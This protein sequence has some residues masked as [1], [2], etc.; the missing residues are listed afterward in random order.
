MHTT[1]VLC[2]DCAAPEG[3]LH[4]FFPYCDQEICPLCLEQLC[5]CP[6]VEALE[7]VEKA[8]R[9]PFL[10]FPCLCAKCGAVDPDFFMV[11]DGEWQAIIPIPY[12][13]LILCRPCYDHLA[14]LQVKHGTL[15]H[16]WGTK[17]RPPV[18]DVTLRLL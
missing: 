14:T 1:P 17:R 13:H 6:H 11:P 18:D 15:G 10:Y 5:G 7:A 16:T 3:A 4:N 2:H 9:L 8:G 12:W